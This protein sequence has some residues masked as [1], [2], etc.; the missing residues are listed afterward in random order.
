MR[1]RTHPGAVLWEDYLLPLDLSPDALARALRVP[2]RRIAA[3]VRERRAVS[4][5][6]ALRLSRYF[7][8]T[9]QFW[10]QLQ[11]AHDLSRAQALKGEEIERTVAPRAS[12]GGGS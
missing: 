6:T 11:T 1:V 8:T 3:V 4:A 7:G 5:D 10:L 9:P 12:G 2:A